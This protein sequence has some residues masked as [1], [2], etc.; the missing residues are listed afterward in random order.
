M[1]QKCSHVELPLCFVSTLVH[2]L[3]FPPEN[4]GE[5]WQGLCVYWVFASLPT[6]AA[7]GGSFLCLQWGHVCGPSALPLVSGLGTM[8]LTDTTLKE[9]WNHAVH[10]CLSYYLPLGNH[11]FSFGILRY[12]VHFLWLSVCGSQLWGL[13][14][15]KLK[16]K[17]LNYICSLL[18]CHTQY[19]QF[20]C[21]V[22][23][24]TMQPCHCQSH[25]AW[26]LRIPFDCHNILTLPS[27]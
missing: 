7:A 1:E 5:S 23:Q 27:C 18:S 19:D 6:E 17:C 9:T 13:S 21:T 20:R 14:T 2:L 3:L 26:Y 8:L 10:C 24:E 25:S 4:L 16:Y 15:L 11:S 12:A 22:L